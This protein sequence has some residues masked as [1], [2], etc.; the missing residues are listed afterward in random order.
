MRLEISLTEFSSDFH[1]AIVDSYKDNAQFSKALVVGVKSGIYIPRN[2]L[3]YLAIPRVQQLCIPYTKVE[4]GRG[5]KDGKNLH[6]IVIS[7]AHEIVGNLGAGKIDN[8]L[9]EQF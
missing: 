2:G 9:R 6:K 5:K 7:H 1:Q 3:L 4:G 8:L